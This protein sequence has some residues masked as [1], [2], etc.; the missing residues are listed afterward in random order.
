MTN[1]EAAKAMRET[2]WSV[3][4]HN[5]YRL[6][7]ERMTFW[8]WTHPNGRWVKGEGE[9]DEVALGECLRAIPAQPPAATPL[10]GEDFT[11]PGPVVAESAA[12]DPRDAALRLARD[13]IVALNA[14]IDAFWNDPECPFLFKMRSNTWLA[15]SDMQKAGPTLLAAIDAI[16]AK[17]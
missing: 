17:P 15:I 9:T 6:N 7:G 3:A 5:D 4:I 8:L 1:H 14:A 11:A 16:G 10:T 12:T 2:G 13:Y